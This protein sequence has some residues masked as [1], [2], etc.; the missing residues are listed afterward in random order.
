MTLLLL[1]LMAVAAVAAAGLSWRARRRR[2][3]V[4]FHKGATRAGGQVIL[5]GWLTLPLIIFGVASAYALAYF[6]VVVPVL[7]FGISR[8]L[9]NRG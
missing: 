5:L 3:P 2:G 1:G 6:L 7:A 8:E 9:R 4:R